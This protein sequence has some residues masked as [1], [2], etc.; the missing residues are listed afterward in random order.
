M[1][2]KTIIGVICFTILLVIIV[3]IYF[4][5]K[6]NISS[7]YEEK[8]DNNLTVINDE[9]EEKEI[10]ETINTTAT[11]ILVAY[12]SLPESSDPNNM[13]EEG[14]NS[15]I[16]IDG[17]VLGNNEYMAQLIKEEMNADIFRIEAKNEYDVSDHQKLIDYAKEEQN[18]NARPEIKEKITNFDEYDTIFI[19][20]PIWW[21][22]LPQILYTFLESYDF[23]GKNIYLFNSHGGSGLS[24]TV[25][26]ITLKLDGANV[27]SNALSISRNNMETAPDRVD[28]WLRNLGF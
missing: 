18:T 26:A 11:K 23:S 1:N 12:F 16:I 25:E 27:N 21:G 4:F 9:T 7:N 24:G 2:R 8:L 6:K 10:D 28:K 5:I 17:K 13:T 19:G 20:Y 14:E 22:D 3:G 15:S